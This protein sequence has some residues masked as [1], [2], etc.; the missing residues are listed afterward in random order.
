[1]YIPC[2]TVIYRELHMQ[3]QQQQ[4]H[5][6]YNL[7]QHVCASSLSCERDLYAMVSCRPANIGPDELCHSRMDCT[8][9]AAVDK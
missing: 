4:L 3:Q 9:E 5:C 6:N 7:L 1:M 8:V 2:A